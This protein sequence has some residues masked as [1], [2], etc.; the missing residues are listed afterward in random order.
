MGI[1]TSMD[2][3]RATVISSG[4]CVGAVHTHT[5]THTHVYINICVC[6]YIS[7]STVASWDVGSVRWTDCRR[8]ER[9][10]AQTLIN[11]RDNCSLYSKSILLF[12]P[13][14]V[15]SLRKGCWFPISMLIKM[16]CAL[17]TLLIMTV[18]QVTVA[19]TYSHSHTLISTSDNITICLSMCH[20]VYKRKIWIYNF[21]LFLSIRV[22]GNFSV[23]H[24]L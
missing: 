1:K 19:N 15:Y 20:L 10:R 18:C 8:W 9:Q 21:L 2:L 24:L 14:T 6:I 5:H 17:S 4:G 16:K 23:F 11:G 3:T 13:R 12:T 7:L 22:L